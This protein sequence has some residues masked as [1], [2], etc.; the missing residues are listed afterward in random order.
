[1]IIFP[2]LDY[3]FT[4]DKTPKEIYADLNSVTKSPKGEIF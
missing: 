4:T 1:M 3:S 2:S